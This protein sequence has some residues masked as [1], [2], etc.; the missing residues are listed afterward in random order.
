MTPTQ[1]PDFRAKEAA[2]NR[3]IMRQFIPVIWKQ[4][5]IAPMAIKGDY[6]TIGLRSDVL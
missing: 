4:A 1:Y 3:N 6:E 2:H 5:F